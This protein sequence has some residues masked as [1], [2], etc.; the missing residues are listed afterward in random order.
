[1]TTQGPGAL[2]ESGG[3]GKAIRSARLG[4]FSSRAIQC[5]LARIEAKRRNSCYPLGIMLNDLMTAFLV[6]FAAVTT[7]GLISRIW[8]Y[9]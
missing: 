8:E 6:A 2:L 1:M 9:F 5:C 3:R 4:P 7:S